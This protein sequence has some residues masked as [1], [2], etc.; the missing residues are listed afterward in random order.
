M[1]LEPT[2]S[3]IKQAAESI[4]RGE[5]VAFPTE[6]VYGLGADAFNA[7]AITKIYRTK[8]R[9]ASNPLIVHIS[10]VDTLSE[11]TDALSDQQQR[12]IKRLAPLWPGPL[13]LVLP[14]HA[15]VPAVVSAG[16]PTIA[17]RIPR[18]PVA[19][20]L[21][22]QAGT[23][24]AA[25]SA[26]R[27]NYVSPT[28]AAHVQG[29][30]GS[31][32]SFILDGGEATVGIESTVVSLVESTPKILRL[33]SISKETLEQLLGT[34][35]APD[36][37]ARVVVAL[38]PGMGLKHYSPR[39]PLQYVDVP[40]A[41]QHQRIGVIRFDNRSIPSSLTPTVVHTLSQRGDAEEVAHKL[42]AALRELD[43]AGLDLILIDRCARTGLGAAIMDRLDRAVAS[44]R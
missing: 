23:P 40:L 32:V 11:L 37:V 18:H 2:A 10:S 6:T 1:I 20:E 13:S 22:R 3:A 38:S 19:L 17:V 34:V 7:D 21:I 44:D 29:E 15:S 4:R 16:H 14:R 8:G 12:W 24:L 43:E 28:C 36:T 25:P 39:T 35:E 33:G 26:N 5:L 31:A 9:P 41:T 30:L 42:Y 27:S